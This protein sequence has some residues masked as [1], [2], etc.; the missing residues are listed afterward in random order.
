MRRD[1]RHVRDG[2][3]HEPAHPAG[4]ALATGAAATGGPPAHR[5]RRAFSPMRPRADTRGGGTMGSF[6]ITTAIPYVN[7]GAAPGLRPRAGPGGRAGPLPPSVWPSHV[8]RDRDRREQLDER[9]GR[10]ARRPLRPR[11]GRRQCRSV[12]RPRPAPC[13]S[14]TTISSGRPP[15][16]VTARAWSASGQACV[17][18][19]RRL[20]AAL[21]RPVLCPVRAVLRDR[22]AASTA[23]APTTTSLPRSSRR[24]ITSSGSP[25]IPSRLARAACR[26]SAAAWC[27]SRATARSRRSSGAG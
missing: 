11:A 23:A 15:I 4:G 24:R 8:V 9:P 20:Q 2:H 16:R 26:E 25:A 27:R 3:G 17:A 6:Y 1:G 12:P 5:G 22:R 14:A 19:R 13:T 18:R 21:P 10:R 7:G